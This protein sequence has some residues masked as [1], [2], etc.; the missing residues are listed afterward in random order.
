MERFA[1]R[2]SLGVFVVAGALVGCS[3]AP[4]STPTPKDAS[5]PSEGDAGGP[6]SSTNGSTGFGRYIAAYCKRAHACG[7][8][9]SDCDDT[10][11]PRSTGEMTGKLG[12]APLRAEVFDAFAQCFEQ[13]ACRKFDEVCAAKV[14]QDL[15]G[16]THPA[17]GACK[18]K[19]DAC[20]ACDGQS[21]PCSD[22]NSPGGFGLDQCELFGALTVDAQKRALSCLEK[23]CGE[24][25]ECVRGVLRPQ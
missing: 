19:A 14:F 13:A 15:G 24:A 22:G 6:T 1:A 4:E 7:Q 3:P 2:G 17:Y 21:A 16:T 18:A 5:T 25:A 23:G 9:V 10:G 12:K 11:V 20:R 8:T